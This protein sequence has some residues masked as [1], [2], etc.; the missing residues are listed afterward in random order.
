ME[1]NWPVALNFVSGVMLITG[2]VGLWLENRQL[3]RRITEL[4]SGVDGMIAEPQDDSSRAALLDVKRLF[5]KAPDP[6]Q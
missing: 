6:T 3:R 5:T 2:G 4:E 1:I